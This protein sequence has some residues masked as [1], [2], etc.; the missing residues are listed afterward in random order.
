MDD[1]RLIFEVENRT[2]LYDTAHP[3]YKDNS[4]KEREWVKIADVLGTST[5]KCK[6]RWRNLRDVFVKKNR[7]VQ[8]PRGSAKVA[9]KEWKFQGIM[10]FLLPYVQPRPS[11]GSL[12][13][14]PTEDLD[15]EGTDAEERPSGTST[16]STSTE[17]EVMSPSP[18]APPAKKTAKKRKGAVTPVEERILSILENLTSTNTD[19]ESY[20]FALSTVPML[21]KLSC[22]KKRRA[23]RAILQILEELMDE[24]DAQQT[25]GPASTWGHNYPAHLS[26]PTSPVIKVED[27]HSS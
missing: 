14:K 24:P 16:P 13:P 7:S 3:L 5:E 21:S 25:D 26:S 12:C 18:A 23:K 4:Q 19:D 11:N 17:A 10:S 9:Q 8:P 27:F 15:R 1:E 6:S 2:V 22:H 20:Y